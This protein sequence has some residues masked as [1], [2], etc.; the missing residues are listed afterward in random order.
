M[1]N[2]KTIPNVKTESLKNHGHQQNCKKSKS[3]ITL[4]Q[5]KSRLQLVTGANQDMTLAENWSKSRLQLVTG[6]NQ[7]ATSAENWRK[8]KRDFSGKLEQT[9]TSA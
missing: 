8:P 3:G 7:D 1:V 5:S 9:D 6:A 4:H 2:K